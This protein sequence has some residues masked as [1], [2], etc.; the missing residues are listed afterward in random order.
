M[1]GNPASPLLVERFSTSTEAQERSKCF[2]ECPFASRL[3]FHDEDV[4]GPM[5]VFPEMSSLRVKSAASGH[6]LP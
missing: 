2:I 1:D 4:S 3:G 6:H 5:N